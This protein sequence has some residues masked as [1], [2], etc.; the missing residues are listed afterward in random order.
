MLNL[1]YIPRQTIGRTVSRYE[2]RNIVNQLGSNRLTE[3]EGWRDVSGYYE[4]RQTEQLY[5]SRTAYSGQLTGNHTLADRA[6]SHIDWSASYSYANRYQP[7]R[8]IVERE[9]NPTNF[10]YDYSIDQNSIQRLYTA[11]DENM[12]T[13]AGNYR[14]KLFGTKAELRAG[15][16][17]EYKARVYKTREFIYKWNTTNSLP[18]GFESLPTDRI[19]AP[20]N[21]GAP[22]GIHIQDETDNR[23]NYRA[24]NSIAAAYAA[25]SAP[26]GRFDIYAGL[27]YEHCRTKLVSFTRP[28][29]AQYT[30]TYDFDYD[31]L[32]PSVNA[33]MEIDRRSQLRMSY[34][35]SVNRQ[36]MRELSP[37]VYYDFD[38]FSMVS[39]NPDLKQATIHNTDLRYEFY[40]SPDET[41]SLAVFDKLFRNPIEWY[42]VDA[43]GSYQYS[44]MNAERA[45]NYGVELDARKKLDFVG[46]PNLTATVNMSLIRSAVHISHF[47]V[48]Y[49]RPM[50][51]QSPYLINVGLVWQGLEKRL[52]VGGFYNRTGRRIIGIGRV[53]GANSFNNNLPDMYECPRDMIDLTCSYKISKTVELRAAARDLLAQKVRYEQRPQ[54]IDSN[55]AMQ[56]RSQT[57]REYYSGRSFQITASATF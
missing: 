12:A 7:D 18:A 38:I 35:M 34:G 23:N 20:E 57:P 17:G 55:G 40:P 50:Q 37:S 33:T 54:F 30:R 11:L 2:L 13:V 52:S 28:Q 27:R 25:V 47:G 36:E 43:G 42:Y 45:H 6:A 29:S 56:T 26:L 16:Y 10:V 15:L 31:N 22:G 24:D 32:F 48:E 14:R 19:M 49:D 39:G 46:A 8:R 5:Q 41:V 1:S 4:Q 21:L 3:R 53:L 44:F 51:G 9:K